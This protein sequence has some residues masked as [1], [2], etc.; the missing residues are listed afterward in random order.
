M[1]PS[2]QVHLFSLILFGKCLQYV[3]RSLPCNRNLYLI[4][5]PN[6]L[7][8]NCLFINCLFILFYLFIH[9]LVCSL[10][11]EAGDI[12]QDSAS[13]DCLKTKWSE[14]HQPLL[15]IVSIFDIICD[16]KRGIIICI[17]SK[18]D[19]LQYQEHVTYKNIEQKTIQDRALRYF[20]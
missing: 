3:L 17:A 7:Y 19:Y 20:S 5:F 2:L 4:I 12:Y 10:D 9:M 15:G 6:F 1:V 14:F 13:S 8:V 16:R 18:V 11:L